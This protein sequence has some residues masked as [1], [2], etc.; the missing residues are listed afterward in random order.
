MTAKYFS[1]RRNLSLHRNIIQG[2]LPPAKLLL[3]AWALCRMLFFLT[4]PIS[5]CSEAAETFLLLGDSKAG[6]SCP[7]AMLTL[8]WPSWPLGCVEIVCSGSVDI[9]LFASIPEEQKKEE[10][11]E[12]FDMHGRAAR[13]NAGDAARRLVNLWCKDGIEPSE[14]ARN[15][16]CWIE[17]ETWW[18]NQTKVSWLQ[19]WTCNT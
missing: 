6:L 7:S 8:R 5:A 17:S 10:W 11:F 16:Y 19:K 12:V 3:S 13:W 15:F 14:I 18:L 4:G 1:I 2:F 9:V